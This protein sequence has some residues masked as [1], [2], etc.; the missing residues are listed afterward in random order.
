MPPE[1]L[2]MIAA[3]AQEEGIVAADIPPL[4]PALTRIAD[5]GV[6]AQV[7]KILPQ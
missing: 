3:A 5:A 1:W 4:L 6:V 2:E 7:E